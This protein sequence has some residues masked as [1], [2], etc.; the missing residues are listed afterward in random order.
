MIGI[1]VGLAS[2]IAPLYIQELSPTRLRGRMVVL[3]VVM[4]TLGQVI[5]Y[6]IDA[7]FE[8]V[9]GGWRWMVGLS[10]VPA[11]LQLAV[12]AFLPESR[13]R[14]GSCSIVHIALTHGCGLVGTARIL[15]RRGSMEAAYRV[16]ARVYTTAT[17]EQVERKV[18]EP[19]TRVVLGVERL[20][21]DV[22]AQR[23]PRD[24]STKYRDRQL[25]HLLATT[26]FNALDS[27][28]PS[29]IEYVFQTCTAFVGFSTKPMSH[30]TP[31]PTKSLLV[32]CKHF[33]SCVDSI[34][35]CII[36][37]RSS[38]RSGLINRRR[39]DSSFLGPTLCLRW[40]RSSS[41]LGSYLGVTVL[42]APL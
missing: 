32:A 1:G 10:V 41:S 13:E 14:F 2:C 33:N 3:N 19:A 24:G 12:L 21:Y 31:S 30:L 7:G 15:V 6:G 22:L 25:D 26:R 37:R 40:L 9:N 28:E 18:N 17:P 35:S 27:S 20:I 23:P 4:I 8:N 5:A 36:R 29:C 34:R 11:A 16:L 42:T 39:L 38:R